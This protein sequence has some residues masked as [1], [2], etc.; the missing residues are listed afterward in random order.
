MSTDPDLTPTNAGRP[1]ILTPMPPGLW[2]VIGGGVAGEQAA[3][4]AL[5]L[6]ADV[7]VID[8]SLSEPTIEEL[9]GTIYL[10]GTAEA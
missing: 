5:G 3:A 2:L 1:V 8:I 6:G 9:V 4:N 7:T 10:R